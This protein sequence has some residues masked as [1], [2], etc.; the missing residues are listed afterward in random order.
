MD[1]LKRTAV[2]SAAL[3]VMAER[4]DSEN[5][6]GRPDSDKRQETLQQEVKLL[7]GDEQNPDVLFHLAVQSYFNAFPGRAGDQDV[8]LPYLFA[9]DQAL[10]RLSELKTN[11]ALHRLENIYSRIRLD[12]G[13]HLFLRGLIKKAKADLKNETIKKT[14]EQTS[15]QSLSGRSQC[16]GCTK[17]TV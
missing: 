17:V 13:E 6:A 9:W 15:P 14:T 10:G 4:R 2:F 5:A 11:E 12:G 3:Q 7:L 8:D 16:G 1:V